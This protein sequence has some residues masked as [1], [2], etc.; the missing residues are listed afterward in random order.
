ML[1][2]FSIFSTSK[3]WYQTFRWIFKVSSRVCCLLIKAN[4]CR[5][6]SAPKWIVSMLLSLLSQ[7]CQR[8]CGR[9]WCESGYEW[10]P[11]S[12]FYSWCLCLA[13]LP[14]SLCPSSWWWRVC[15]HFFMPSGCTGKITVNT[16]VLVSLTGTKLF[17]RSRHFIF[18][19]AVCF[20]LRVEFQNKFYSGTG[21]KFCPF[22]FSLLP[23]SLEHDGI[24]W[25][26]YLT[27]TI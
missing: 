19:T 16:K 17:E 3:N 21:V 23:S 25:R 9:W 2:H 5:L 20:F 8:C 11:L 27:G 10:T 13:C 24:L 4:K 18:L 6:I 1:M 22:S 7:S 26:I 14:F 12:G 15:L